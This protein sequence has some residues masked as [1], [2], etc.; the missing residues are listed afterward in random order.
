MS[1]SSDSLCP[2]CAKIDFTFF[3]KSSGLPQ[4][5]SGFPPRLSWSTLLPEQCSFCQ[6]LLHCISAGQGINKPFEGTIYAQ[7]KCRE[8]RFY[9]EDGGA[10]R[11]GRKLDYSIQRC[12]TPPLS[13]LIDELR[14]STYFDV[15]HTSTFNILRCQRTQTL[16][17]CM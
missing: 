1:P 13:P 17:G 12:Q 11:T 5:D 3:T 6:L 8:L 2:Q 7:F 15:Q 9:I 14:R 4:F 10:Q 16:V